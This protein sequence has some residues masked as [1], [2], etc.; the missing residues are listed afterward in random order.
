M[1]GPIQNWQP[2][3]TYPGDMEDVLLLEADGSVTVGCRWGEMGWLAM[4]H[5]EVA[6]SWDS[7]EYEPSRFRLTPTHWMPRPAPLAKVSP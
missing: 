6:W 3:E 1:S 4:V 5:G 2:I 7:P